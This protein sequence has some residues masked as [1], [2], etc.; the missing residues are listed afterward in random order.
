MTET[1]LTEALIETLRATPEGLSLGEL[2]TALGTLLREVRAEVSSLE[3][4]GSLSSS[5]VER[6]GR[7]AKIRAFAL[8]ERF[9]LLEESAEQ[10]LAETGTEA[11]LSALTVT[12]LLRVADLSL[13]ERLPRKARKGAVVAAI[14]AAQTPLCAV[15][16]DEPVDCADEVC[17]VC[18][19]AAVLAANPVKPAKSVA[20]RVV[21]RRRRARRPSVDLGSA[22]SAEAVAE[23]VAVAHS[24]RSARAA[25]RE[26]A[27]WLAARNNGL[28]EAEL[29]RTLLRESGRLSAAN[30][31]INMKKDGFE[32]VLEGGELVQRLVGWR[33]N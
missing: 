21:V 9:L 4:A 15:C 26:V 31:T 5:L 20:D 3:Q 19:E 22:L 7:S 14:L 17:T 8:S 16:A 18:A 32:R 1:T 12:Q 30:F 10:V 2:A 13:G 11:E 27:E 28:I 23:A 24:A 29:L 25:Q 33:K 6:E